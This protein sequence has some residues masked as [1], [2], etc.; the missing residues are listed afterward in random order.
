[1]TAGWFF[2]MMKTETLKFLCFIT[3]I[4]GAYLSKAKFPET[5]D[6]KKTDLPIENKSS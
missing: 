5:I 4:L 6:L 1:L 2:L 3:L